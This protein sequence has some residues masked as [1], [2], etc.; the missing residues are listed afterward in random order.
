MK[1]CFAFLFAFISVSI[2]AQSLKVSDE[3]TLADFYTYALT[4]G[5]SYEWLQHLTTQIGGRM[6]GTVAA[7]KAVKWVE[8][9]MLDAGFDKVWLQP[10]MVPHWERGDK[11][12][13]Y[14]TINNKK[15]NLPIAALGNSIAT[16]KK[17]LLAEVVEVKSIAEA[18]NLGE[19]LRGKIVFFNAVM[20][21][22][23]I[24]PFTGYSET[25]GMRVN[26]AKAVGKYGAVG[27]I[28]RS[29][30]TNLDDYPHTGVM[31]YRGIPENEK[32]PAAAIS[33]NAAELLSKHLKENPSLKFYFKQNCKNYEPKLSYNVIGEITG[34]VNPE[35]FIVVGG[36]LDSWDLGQGA[37]DNGTGVVQ[38]IEAARLFRLMNIQPNNTIRVVLFMDE[39][40]SGT[41]SIKYAADAKEKNEKHLGAIETDSGGFTPRG[42]SIDANSELFSLVQTWK[43][44]FEKYGIYEFFKGGSG[45]DTSDLKSDTILLMGYKP[46]AQ[47]YFDFHH[48]ATDTFDKVNKRELEL[49]A[50]SI[51]SILYLMDSYLK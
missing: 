12:V 34:A 7:D 26:G 50:G 41:G 11:E 4:Q 23:H 22:S 17:G 21:S 6:P 32:I 24:R 47:R 45:A 42:F 3:K 8:K 16:P 25:A 14:Y 18:E 1:Y 29:L 10:V 40:N 37:H 49:G 39:E 2:N 20:K 48:A 51:A 44:L 31:S 30:T 28:V 13:A 43:P 35:N 46:D 19:K 27:V 33:T 38:S 36:H 5:K 15:I 9:T